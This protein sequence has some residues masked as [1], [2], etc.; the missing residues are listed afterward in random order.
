MLKIFLNFDSFVFPR[1]ASIIYWIGLVIIIIFTVAGATSALILGSDEIELGLAGGILG[2]SAS[3]I[4]GIGGII[5]WRVVVEF[6]LVVFSISE[7]L[8]DIREQGK[9][10]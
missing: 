6:W 1:I 4:A 3:V 8:R 10:R 2:F 7:T 5:I 9:E